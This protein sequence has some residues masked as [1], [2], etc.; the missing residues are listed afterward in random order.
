MGGRATLN[1]SKDTNQ[2]R[3]PLFNIYKEKPSQ[4][5]IDAINAAAREQGKTYGKLQAEKL[6]EKQHLEMEA[7]A[8]G[9]LM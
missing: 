9:A 6:L 1:K 7:R 3:I 4:K 8:N 5:R 2:Y